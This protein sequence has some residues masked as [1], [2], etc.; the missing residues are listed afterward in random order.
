MALLA[1]FSVVGESA[2]RFTTE[3]DATRVMAAAASTDTLYQLEGTL[4]RPFLGLPEF[5]PG[6]DIGIVKCSFCVS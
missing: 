4:P 1:G 6:I 3:Y 2:P 5:L